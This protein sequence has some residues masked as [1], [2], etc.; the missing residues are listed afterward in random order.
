[1]DPS[2]RIGALSLP[3]QKDRNWRLS[4]GEKECTTDH[5]SRTTLQFRCE[6]RNGQRNIQGRGLENLKRRIKKVSI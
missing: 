5:R 4:S 2:P 3:V 1:M 6:K